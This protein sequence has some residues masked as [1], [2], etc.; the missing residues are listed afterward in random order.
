MMDKHPRDRYLTVVGRKP[1]LEALEQK[2][3]TFGELLIDRRL[4]R[5]AVREILD[6][7]HNANV[8]PTFCDIKKVNRRSRSPKQDQGVAL[9][10]ETPNVT[11]LSDWTRLN[12]DG[13]LF[14]PDGVTTP[15]NVGMMIRSLAAA[16]LSAL[17]L[18]ERNTPKLGPLMI[19]ASAGT[20][21]QCEILKAPDTLSAIDTLKAAGWHICALDARGKSQ[22][23]TMDIPPRT[24]WVFGN[25]TQGISP[26]VTPH[27]DEWVNIP[28]AAGVESL[29][30]AMSATVVAFEHVRRQLAGTRS[31]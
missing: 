27:V 28:M 22:V 8:K 5:E 10:I 31:V 24:A 1:V 21:F 30:V 6:S 20:A 25:E 9:D 13:V 14:I 2:G 19:K 3:H 17:V 29:N 18:P 16:G 7:A 12:K 4:K 15:G 23:F 26:A 11:Q